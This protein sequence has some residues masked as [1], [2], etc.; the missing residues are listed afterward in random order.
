MTSALRGERGEPSKADIA[1]KLSKGGCVN[2]WTRG[3]GLKKIPKFCGRHISIAPNRFDAVCRFL[4]S[5][6]Y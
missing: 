4:K 5:T 6:Q 2:L 3:G 1:I